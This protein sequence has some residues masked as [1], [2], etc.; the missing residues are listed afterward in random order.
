MVGCSVGPD[1]DI[2]RLPRPFGFSALLP[3]FLPSGNGLLP[4]VESNLVTRFAFFAY[5][6]KQNLRTLQFVWVL[7]TPLS[8]EPTFARRP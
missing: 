7:C 1:C 3:E 8:G 6:G 4:F 2:R 5:T